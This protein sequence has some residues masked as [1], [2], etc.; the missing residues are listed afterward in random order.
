MLIAISSNEGQTITGEADGTE[1][2]AEAV[3]LA[4]S[5]FT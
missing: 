1:W 2:A 3:K 5:E 4:S